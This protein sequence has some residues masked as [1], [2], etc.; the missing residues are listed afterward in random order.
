[1]K[2]TPIVNHAL[3]HAGENLYRAE[4]SGIYYA[5]FKRD[6]KQIRRS[7]KTTDKDLARRKLAELRNQ[8]N[9][10]TAD[11]AKSLPFAEYDRD[12]PDVLIGGLAKRWLDMAGTTLKPSSRLRRECAIKQLAPHFRGVTVRNVRRQHVENWA[13]AHSKSGRS[14]RDHNITRDTLRLILEY[15]VEHGMLLDNPARSLK[16]RKEGKKT[17]LI[18]TVDQFRAILAQMRSTE[19]KRDGEQ[20]A[21]LIEFL[22]LSGC[23]I[24]EATAMTWGDVNFELQCF[25]VTG[26]ATGTKNHEARTVPL[27]PSL[28][29]FLLRLRDNLPALPKPDAP[30]FEVASGRKSLDN[31]CKKLGLPPYHHHTFR[32]FFCSN[33]IEKTGGHFKT[34]A[35]WLGHKDGG[36]LVARTYGHLRDEF[37]AQLA[38]RMTLDEEP[39]A[40]VVPMPQAA[41]A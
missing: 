5:L 31:A 34:V 7:L 38:K 41:N 33:A 22:A 14:P 28:Q 12:K 4:T 29:A 36:V 26:G 20:S 2:T 18:P 10:L 9:R 37:S 17:L 6:G 39:P 27:F 25:T 1:M 24:A 30:L 8:V 3:H 23:R 15:A 40:N 16:R 11:D 13:M 21:N 32:H 35:G 19:G